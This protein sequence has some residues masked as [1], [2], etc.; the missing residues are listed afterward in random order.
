MIEIESF[1]DLHTHTRYPDNN[2]FPSVDIEFAA[3]NGGY[4]DILAMPNSEI[5]ID[6]IK[7]LNKARAMDN[8]LNINVHRVGALTKNLEG[9]ELVNY[10]EFIENGV[11]IFSDDGKSLIDNNLADE[12]FKLISSLNA[13]IFQ[14]CESSCH[15]EPGDIAAP[16]DDETLIT[17]DEEE[18]SE[19]LL[20]D[21]ELVAKYGT[22]YHAQHLSSK[23]CVDLIKEAKENNLPITSE[24]TPHHI[25][26][27]NENLDT[28]NGLF[29]MYPPIRTEEDR[30]SLIDGLL[31]NVID[32]IATDHAPHPENTKTVD[33]KSAA[34]GV[35]GLESAFPMLYSSGILSLEEIKRF[36]IENPRKI[37][38]EAGYEVKKSQINIWQPCDKEFTTKSK[39][40]NSIFEKRNTKI[41]KVSQ[42]V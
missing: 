39:F 25:L 22:R 1:I 5:V 32:A 30:L 27:N 3:I 19:V 8:K 28:T 35:V 41:E 23:K 21:I 4:S 42:N 36:M 29:K 10:K 37:L 15:S 9:K 31:S 20:R 17:I 16:N 7:N 18:E 6:N 33:F 14:H 2:N 24:V 13:A 26:E 12:A 34:R 11:F 40:N 38:S